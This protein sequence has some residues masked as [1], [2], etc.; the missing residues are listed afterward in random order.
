VV[1]AKPVREVEV[2]HALIERARRRGLGVL[3]GRG[4][5]GQTSAC[6]AEQPTAE[7]QSKALGG[8]AVSFSRTPAPVPKYTS[9][10]II[11][12]VLA[13]AHVLG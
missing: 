2:A 13:Q 10:G 9:S 11:K 3:V 6:V 5:V 8:Y 12:R 7:Q 4:S 1:R